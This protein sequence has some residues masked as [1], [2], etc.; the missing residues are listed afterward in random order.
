VEKVT[1]AGTYVSQDYYD[2]IKQYKSPMKAQGGSLFIVIPDNTLQPTIMISNFHEGGPWLRVLKNKSL[3]EMWELQ[4]GNLKQR[5]YNIE[6]LSADKIK[7]DTTI[8]VKISPQT[9]PDNHQVLEEILFKGSYLRPNNTAIEFQSNGQIIGPIN[10]QF[11]KPMIDYYDAARQID[12]IGLGKSEEKFDW[13]GFKFK[14]DTLELYNLKCLTF[15]STDNKC[16]V[17]DFG[18]LTYK[19]LYK[20]WTKE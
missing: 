19:L 2:K 14:G 16:V 8:F 7:L 11:Y 9:N 13:Y 15:D 18:E 10:F 12:Q 5:L 4:D 20:E 6:I 1:F 17:V 3:Y